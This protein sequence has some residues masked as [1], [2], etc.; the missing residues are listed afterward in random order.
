[1][2]AGTDAYRCPHCGTP[3]AADRLGG[4]CPACFGRS[5]EEWLAVPALDTPSSCPDVPGWTLTG[6]LGAGGMG[7][8]YRA[9]SNT[10]GSPA[11]LKVLNARW[12]G[13]PL[14]SA[15]FEAEAAALRRLSHPHIVQVQALTETVDGR[16]CLVME[17]VDGCDLSRLLRAGKLPQERAMDLFLKICEAVACAHDAGLL[18][19]DIKPSNILVGDGGVVKLADFGLVKSLASDSTGPFIGGLTATTDQ[20]G[21]AYYLAPERITGC[22]DRGARGDVYSLGV[23]LYHLLAGRMPLGKFQPLSALTGLPRALDAVVSAA[24][25]ADPDNRTA[26]VKDLAGQA[27]RIWQ[28]HRSGTGRRRLGRRLAVAL[29]MGAALAV[30]AI[31]GAAWQRG[32]TAIPGRPPAAAT[33]QEPWTNSLGMNF[34]PVPGTRVLFSTCETRRREYDLYRA[35]DRAAAPWRTGRAERLAQQDGSIIRFTEDGALHGDDSYEHPAWPVTPDFPAHGIGIRDAQHFCL[36]LTLKD[37]AEGWLLE[38]WHYR[39]PTSAE[40]IAAAGGTSAARLPGNIAGE[41][42]RS[43]PDRPPDWNV[44]PERDAFLY[45]SPAGSFPVERHGLYDMSGNLSEW[46]QDAP[47]RLGAPA[48][49]SAAFLIGPNHLQAMK[50]ADALTFLSPVKLTRRQPHAGFRVVL[51]GPPPPSVDGK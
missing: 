8:V 18:H 28:Q 13:D 49:Q 4:I 16:L 1:M 36:W 43:Y 5:A 47:E 25:E 10:D 30:A 12:S 45:P 50:G 33:T 11:A 39:L 27:A 15:R 3:T 20:F 22:P 6:V 23:L 31:G 44:L 29:T 41:E 7:H 48:G 42:I 46:V 14:M 19:R 26:S 9:E 51:E 2:N 24:L 40:W 37:R 21:T 34:V 35:A 38:G 32:K 17:Y